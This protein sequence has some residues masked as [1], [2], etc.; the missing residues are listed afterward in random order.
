MIPDRMSDPGFR[1]YRSLQ[2]MDR[3]M[4]NKLVHEYFGVD[5]DIVVAVACEELPQIKSLVK[6]WRGESESVR[7]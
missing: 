2:R 3:S 4:R 1:R 6:R 7:T 5:L